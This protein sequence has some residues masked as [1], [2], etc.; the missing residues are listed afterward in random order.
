[1]KP[2]DAERLL[3]HAGRP[4]RPPDRL[5]RA[6]LRIP[7]GGASEAPRWRRWQ[8][9]LLVA[10]AALAL[11]GGILVERQVTSF[12]AVAAV[13][14]RGGAASARAE[15]GPVDGPNRPVRLVVQH[16]QPGGKGYYELWAT[17]ERPPMMLATFMT[18]ADG[19]CTITFSIPA[20][21]PISDLVVT[22]RSDG[23]IYLLHSNH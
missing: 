20:T 22:P 19:S 3:R 17:D 15:L 23:A 1:M 18:D 16:L 12:H 7:T 9:G 10:A 14:L 21:V 2:E 13:D 5:A 11:S 6:V 8:T 4:A